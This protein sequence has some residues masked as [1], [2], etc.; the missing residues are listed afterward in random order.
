MKNLLTAIFTLFSSLNP[1]VVAIG[2]ASL[3]AVSAFTWAN[4]KWAELITRIDAMTVS[5]FAGVLNVSPLGFVNTFVPL[6]EAL[7][8]FTAWVALL[9]VCT[10]IRIVKSFVP[11]VAS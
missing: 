7:T 1:A 4:S 2:S 3:A 8:Y 9:G 6:Q 10:T 11:T 5:S